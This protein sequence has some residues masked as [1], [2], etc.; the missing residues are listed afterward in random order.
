MC[1]QLCFKSSTKT[2][3]T[4]ALKDAE[5]ALTVQSKK[6][7]DGWGIGYFSP[8]GIP[9]LV[10]HLEPAHESV[11]F[12]DIA[13]KLVTDNILAHVRKAR[14]GDVTLENCHPFQYGEWLYSHNGIIWEW[15]KVKPKLLDAIDPKYHK[16]IHGDSDSEPC[17]YLLL[18][19]LERF[20]HIHGL[21]D[22]EPI[23]EAM[24]KTIRQIHSWTDEAGSKRPPI[25]NFLIMNRDV[26]VASRYGQLQ[27]LFYHQHEHFLE[28]TTDGD[29]APQRE[30]LRYVLIVSEKLSGKEKWEPIEEGSIITVNKGLHCEITKIPI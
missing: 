30:P 22:P 29:A 3:L 24:V 15:E 4:Y 2:D 6:Q 7:K 25:L 28:N 13:G 20:T 5:N 23:R 1:R 12:E 17:F 16:E 14:I 21:T 19:N 27:K 8:K 11:H 9:M 18:T 10:K 26:I